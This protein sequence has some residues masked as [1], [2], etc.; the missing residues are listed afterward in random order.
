MNKNNS[1][2]KIIKLVQEVFQEVLDD[3]TLEIK[4]ETTSKDIPDWDSLN[5][6]ALVINI[7][8]K[9]NIRFTAKEIQD[10]KNVGEMCEGIS[11]KI[12]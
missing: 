3:S 10:F 12:S 5:H 8:K 9:F 7:E 6:I 4:Y 1:F 11:Q 2:E